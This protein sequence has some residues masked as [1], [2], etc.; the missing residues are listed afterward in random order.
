[1]WMTFE[2]DR[3]AGHQV[4]MSG[5]G[6]WGGQEGLPVRGGASR[7]HPDMT[8]SLT[9]YHDH[10]KCQEVTTLIITRIYIWY[11]SYRR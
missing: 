11:I 3:C 8:L 1:M 2:V 9:P 4:V 7:G 6:Q 5:S 10:D